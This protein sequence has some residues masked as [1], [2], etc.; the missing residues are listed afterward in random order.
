MSK[1]FLFD[2]FESALAALRLRLW[3]RSVTPALRAGLIITLPFNEIDL[4]KFHRLTGSFDAT[5]NWSILR[6][7]VI[8]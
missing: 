5:E 8:Y 1:P 3:I 7:V 6:T 4:I 2:M